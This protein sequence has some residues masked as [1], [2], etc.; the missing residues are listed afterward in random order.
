MLDIAKHGKKQFFTAAPGSTNPVCVLP[1]N[2]NRISA[3]IVNNGSQTVY[4]GG[5]P[6]GVAQG[7]ALSSTTGFPLLAGAS[8]TDVSSNDAWWALAASTTG[9]LRIME[10]SASA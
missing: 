7:Q 2:A 3:V 1:A 9:D 10:V 4:L 8:T 6:G 5:D